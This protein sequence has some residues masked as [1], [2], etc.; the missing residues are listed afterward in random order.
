[1][2]LYK[3]WNSFAEA[4]GFIASNF[5]AANTAVEAILVL[6][7][8]FSWEFEDLNVVDDIK[9]VPFEEWENTHLLLNTTMEEHMK[10]IT[11]AQVLY[12]I[13]N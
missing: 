3:Y 10:T 9:E 12:P 13:T 1:M 7:K 4:E 5:I 8:E 6:C 11:H 2:K